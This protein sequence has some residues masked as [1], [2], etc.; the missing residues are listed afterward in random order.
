MYPKNWG[1]C[2]LHLKELGNDQ[3]SRS[4]NRLVFR[5]VYDVIARR[6]RGANRLPS[7][8]L[9]LSILCFHNQKAVNNLFTTKR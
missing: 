2:K 6:G 3:H 1:G 7:F 9:A 8:L 4:F 5:I